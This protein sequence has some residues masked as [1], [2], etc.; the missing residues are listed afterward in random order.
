MIRLSAK[1]LAK[2]MTSGPASQRRILW[3]YKHPDPEGAVQAKYYAEARLA[4]QQFHQ[5]GND[6]STAL[7]SL[8]SLLSKTS[9][10]S[11]RKQDRV[12]NN[13]RALESYIS[14]FGRRK[15]TILAQPNITLIHGEVTVS[16]FPDLYVKEG[17][18]HR[19]IKFDFSKEPPNPKMI[20]IILQVTFAAAQRASLPLRPQDV[21]YLD[22]TRG[23]EHNGARLRAHLMK[24]V[25]AA[26]QTIQD[27]WSRI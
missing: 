17:S 20:T 19:L 22:V 2:Y 4:I 26:C 7:R 14:H 27:V 18:R 16:A 15:L 6:P 11:A 13:I 12:R 10:L 23:G 3:N 8:E 24:D 5:S 1:G 9:R 21:V 25:E